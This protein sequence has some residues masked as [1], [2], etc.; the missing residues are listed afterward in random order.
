[1]RPASRLFR[2][3]LV[4]AP[5]IVA[6]LAAGSVG[7]ASLPPDLHFLTLSTRK[8]SVH[9]H[10]GLE[11]RARVAAALA[12]EI[13]SDLEA[14]YRVRIP[15]VQLVLADD[16]DDPNAFTSV[17]PYPL[18]RVAAAPPDGTDE[19]GRYESW[20]RLA[21]THE[22][23][24]AVHLEQARGLARLGRMVFGRAPFLF[25]NSAAASWMVEGLATYEETRLTAFGRGR[26]A[27]SRMIVRMAALEGR[28]PREDQASGGLDRWPGGHAQYLFGEAF[29]RD[30]SGRFGDGALPALARTHATWP[31]PYID[32]ITSMVVT[33]APFA[34]RWKEWERATRLRFESEA[35][36]LA[37]LGL[38][39]SRPLTRRGVAQIGA[40]V[41]PDG[42]RIAYTS[43][44]LTRQREVR[45]MALDGSQ[46]RRV[47]RRNGGSG[48]AWTPDGRALVFDEPDDYRLYRYWSDLKIVDLGSGRVRRLTRG[49]RAADPDV[50]PDSAAI[51]FVRRTE[52]GS[53]LATV[54]R[55]G[56]SPVD[57]THSAPGTMWSHPRVS[58]RGDAVVAAR[59]TEGGF[60][61]LV[62][63]DLESGGLS[64]LTHD[65]AKDAEPTW[66]ADGAHV[67]FRSDRDGV[68]NLY[69]LRLADGVLL[70]LT[71]VLGGAFTPSLD[72]SGSRLVFS[73]YSSRGYDVHETTIAPGELSEPEAFVD[74]YPPSRVDPLGVDARVGS[75]RPWSHLWPR[76]WMPYVSSSSN[77]TRI[78]AS[79]SGYDPLFRNIYALAVH[80]TSKTERIGFNAVYVYDRYRPTFV[81]GAKDETE[82]DPDGV[83]RTRQAVLSAAYPLQR[84]VRLAQ[85][86]GL[87]WRGEERR[88]ETR[89][90]KDLRLRLS[91]LELSW[92]F[93]TARQYPFTISPIEGTRLYVSLEQELKALGSDASLLK[94]AVDARGYVRIHE[95]HTLAW[96]GGLATTFGEPRLG[97]VYTLGG[98]PTGGPFDLAGIRPAVLRGYPDNAFHGRHIAYASAEYRF[99]LAHPQGGLWSLPAFLRHLHGAVF[100]DAGQAWNDSFA[101]CRVKTAVGA[102]LGADTFLGH[103]LPITGT[104]GVARG[105]S[106]RGKTRAYFRLGLAF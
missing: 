84:S 30:L 18:I 68:S 20:L 23:A 99:P 94:L 103:A 87:A 51:V 49:L 22:L 45:V 78:G 72:P 40:R 36:G 11:A 39:E 26:D 88:L 92:T 35:A 44:T 17:F 19:L 79:T 64:E 60:L 81:L 63:V 24:H 14:R 104:A 105:L 29:L 101:L 97:D 16:T 46:D 54:A 43:A 47:A 10:Q 7:A 59:F 65:R 96:R 28:L 82:A 95:T 21:L 32:E 77:A 50:T 13:L 106:G 56:S 80:R 90:G 83:F 67:V 85:T 41:S 5:L 73:S 4:G 9:F 8:V 31:L 89:K 62:L 33:G 15:R 91:G 34:R 55:D 76:Y 42:T 69:A 86:V 58:P 61:D 93:S 66:S 38:T 70:R 6:G 100:V 98:F 25:P 71:R 75:Y 53:E 3:A 57:L 37:R 74:P 102:A 2:L 1:V 48:L 27:D 52:G 12:T